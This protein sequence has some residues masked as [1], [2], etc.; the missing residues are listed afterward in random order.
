MCIRDRLLKGLPD[1]LRTLNR[2]AYGHTSKKEVYFFLKQMCSIGD[3]FKTHSSYIKEQVLSP[4]GR[5]NKQSQLLTSILK[6][7]ENNYQET[8]LPQLFAM[9]NV[10]AVMNK[11]LENQKTEFF[12]LN[13]YD[14]PDGIIKIQRDIEEMCI[15]DRSHLNLLAIG[16]ILNAS[17]NGS[18]F[19]NKSNLSSSDKIFKKSAIG[20]LFFTIIILPTSTI[21]S[22]FGSCLIN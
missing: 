6:D 11:N 12:N 1:L 21:F 19:R 20:A 5:I 22:G 10:A 9:I 7:I 2:I 8:H 4:D 14:N 18:L 17:S 13:N 3:H 16:S 15:R